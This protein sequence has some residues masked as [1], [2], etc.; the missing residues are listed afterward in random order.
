MILKMMILYYVQV[1]YTLTCVYTM[2]P[3]I[4]VCSL[5][6]AN[7]THL[8]DYE[9]SL[10]WTAVVYNLGMLSVYLQHAQ[11]FTESRLR[12]E[13]RHHEIREIYSTDSSTL[14]FYV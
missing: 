8:V 4:A 2:V 11:V 13:S 3:C 5:K 14:N 10:W 1:T 6:K 7:R 9:H 12:A